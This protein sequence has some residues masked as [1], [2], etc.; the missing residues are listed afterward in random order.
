MSRMDRFVSRPRAVAARRATDS[1]A[2]RLDAHRIRKAAQEVIDGVF[3]EIH[4]AGSVSDE[5]LKSLHFFYGPTFE[6]ALDVYDA[7]FVSKLVGT[8]TKRALFHVQG[9][10]RLPY[11]VTDNWCSCPA[12][13]QTLSHGKGDV[14]KHLLAARLADATGSVATTSVP[15][16]EI[17]RELSDSYEAMSEK[18]N[19]AMEEVDGP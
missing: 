4:K 10:A 14:C 15:D 7:E 12:F 13:A 5:H 16:A 3:A 17:A 2:P 6:K 18:F 1:H 11:T 19:K 9:S 8:D